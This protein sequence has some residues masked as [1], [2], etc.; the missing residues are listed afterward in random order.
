MTACATLSPRDPAATAGTLAARHA[1][2]SNASASGAPTGSPK[3]AG[4]RAPSRGARGSADL[5]VLCIAIESRASAHEEE[6]EEEVQQE[7][8]WLASRSAFRAGPAKTLL[9]RDASAQRDGVQSIM[10]PDHRF[11]SFHLGLLYALP[12]AP[13]TT[14]YRTSNLVA[15]RRV[16]CDG[17]PPLPTETAPVTKCGWSV[18]RVC[19]TEAVGSKPRNESISV[20]GTRLNNYQV[21]SLLGEGG[22]GAV[23]LAE[24][25]FMGRKAAIKV[26]HQDHARDRDLVE[27]FMNEARA[28]NAIGHPNIIDIIDVGQ[29]PSGIPYLMMEFLDG[30][31]L[32]NRI[33]RERPL[34]IAEALEVAVQVAAGL[35]AAHDKG[36]VHRDL[37]PDN[38]FLVPERGS[39]AGR[40]KVL[41]FGIA[42]L[43]GDL[44]AGGAKTKSGSILGTPP[45]MSP[46]QCRGISDDVDHRTDIYALGIILYE[47]LTGS[48]PFTSPGWGDIV[49]MHIATPPRPPREHN[50]AIPVELEGVVLKALAKRADD[51]WP[52]MGAFE[53]ALRALAP[54]AA[55]LG[56][57]GAG[58]IRGPRPGAA[59]PGTPVP[60]GTAVLGATGGT[61]VAGAG[62]AWGEGAGTGSAAPR[63]EAPAMGSA[64]GTAVLTS[65]TL[66]SAT[67]ETVPPSDVRGVARRRRLAAPLAVGAV[68]LC[69]VV[70]TIR[71]V[72]RFTGSSAMQSNPSTAVEPSTARPAPP[73]ASATSSTAATIPVPPPPAAPVPPP[74][75]ATPSVEP[76]APRRPSADDSKEPSRPLKSASV[77]AKKPA[78]RP[79]PR[80]NGK[81]ACDPNF[82]FDAQGDKHFKPECF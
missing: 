10:L 21:V 36:I 59:V 80:S 72:G 53:E 24:H 34:P 63:P 13:V 65:T 74:A 41:D 52:S 48:P 57:H 12:V 66:R 15:S 75:P 69:A 55:A 2:A 70:V 26:L 67:G 62:N 6:Q 42:K 22:M 9:E 16:N 39:L 60:G 7:P 61:L 27:R 4:A 73:A 8:A 79:P 20:I 32:A 78:H 5:R 31:S 51:R 17:Y 47:M 49:H 64:G 33:A 29:L 50:P 1:P 43:R 45:Y 71:A 81:P 44:S 68:V 77:V 82:Y 54:A 23:F 14:K 58:T 37:K 76:S 35:V 25:S 38:V 11:T 30:E 19:D 40:I 3:A 28:A 18:D 56:R 46:E